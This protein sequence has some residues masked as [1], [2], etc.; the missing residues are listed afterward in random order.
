MDQMYWRGAVVV[1]YSK[2][3]PL[4]SSVGLVWPRGLGRVTRMLPG[5]TPLME[6]E[7]TAIWVMM[8]PLTVEG[9]IVGPAMLPEDSWLPVAGQH[10]AA[11][12]GKSDG[13]D[14][15]LMAEQAAERPAASNV[16]EPCRAVVGAGQAGFPIRAKGH[17]SDAML[18]S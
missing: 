1:L 17:G 7:V 10:V 12:G 9:V 4:F 2:P 11:I 13:C 18:M 16:P 8:R 5:E 6:L 3:Q 14:G 15:V